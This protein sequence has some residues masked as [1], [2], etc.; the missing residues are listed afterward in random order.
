MSTMRKLVTVASISL[1]SSF[2]IAQTNDSAMLAMPRD[3]PALGRWIIAHKNG[4]S[5]DLQAEARER[6]YWFINQRVRE[7][8]W[9]DSVLPN[10]SLLAGMFFLASRVGAI[11][12]RAIGLEIM[13]GVAPPDTSPLPRDV[14]LTLDGVLLRLKD[15][16][17]DW[18]LEYPIYFMLSRLQRQVL[19][20]GHEYLLAMLS[21]MF[22]PNAPERGGESQATI[23][24]L[25]AGDLSPNQ[26]ASLWEQ[27]IAVA[28]AD[29]PSDL[30]FHP[31]K[32]MTG[33][34]SRNQMRKE[35]LAVPLRQGSLA[36]LYSGLEGTFQVNRPAF[37]RL[38][39]SVK[40]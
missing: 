19:N 3:F 10:D 11:R 9:P 27:R 5:H 40:Y 26:I 1:A 28:E 22:A 34:D 23:L 21:T 38:L 24:L 31:G 7:R 14:V 20:D 13:P 29:E 37:L 12:A 35:F 36:F 18:K 39:R 8:A 25:A 16:A 30:P 15:E 2:G 4:L 32:Y 33:F 17:L 6:M